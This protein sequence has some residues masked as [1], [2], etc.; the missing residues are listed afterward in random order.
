MTYLAQMTQEILSVLSYSVLSFY[1]NGSQNIRNK[2][3]SPL[4]VIKTTNK[5][6]IPDYRLRLS[7]CVVDYL[8]EIRF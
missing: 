1:I 2:E 7:V 8:S 6:H 3:R 5:L 4:S